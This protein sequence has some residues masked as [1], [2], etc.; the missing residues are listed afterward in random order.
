MK[1]RSRTS[2][3]RRRTVAIVTGTRAEFGLLRPV[4]DAV[5]T[6]RRLRLQL[7]AAGAHFL[8]PARTIREVRDAC[9]I[10]AEVRM[11]RPGATGRQADAEAL[12][13]GVSGFARAF[14]KLKPDWV[15]VLGDRIEAFAAA[16]AASVAGIAVCHVHGGDRAEG[17]ADE[18]MRHAITKLAHLHCAATEQSAERIV[19]MGERREHVHVTGSPAIDGLRSIEP[20]DDLRF[21]ELGSPR[22]IVLLHP[23]GAAS[24]VVRR[25]VEDTCL[26]VLLFAAAG[27]HRHALW[28]MP[29]HD[30]GREE[31][32]RALRES[33]LDLEQMRDHLP[34][35]QL[36]SLFKRLAR[37]KDGM[38]V[39]NSSAGLIE[40]AAIGLPVVNI[41]DRQAGRERA[42]NVIDVEIPRRMDEFQGALG[43]AMEQAEALRPKPSKLFGD[44]RAGA[45]IADLLVRVN[46]RDPALLRKHNT[47]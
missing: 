37:S 41:G 22:V 42:A 29:N 7:I 5:Q 8:P 34:R 30:A 14:A 17:I 25:V 28:L 21:K 32:V 23:W 6:S 19:K 16:S 31:I 3:A 36:L 2:A 20:L 39:G 43:T 11:Q 9:A 15:V 45:R 24:A 27:E 10:A 26:M 38:L 4:I 1:R 46:P 18:A 40:A 33:G 13:R 35:E 44:G 47:Y 12:G